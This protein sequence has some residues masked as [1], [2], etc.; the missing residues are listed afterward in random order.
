MT[1]LKELLFGHNSFPLDM[2]GPP[3]FA[4]RKCSFQL[5]TLVSANQDDNSDDFMMKVLD[6]NMSLTLK[7]LYWGTY[8]YD[9][10]VALFGTIAMPQLTSF[11]GSLRLVKHV[12]PGRNVTSL[13]IVEDNLDI[14]EDMSQFRAVEA[15][16]RCI[17]SLCLV[18]YWHPFESPR[19]LLQLMPAL[20]TV[21]ISD[22]FL[23]VYVSH[24]S[25][26]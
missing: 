22:I 8:R 26:S 4:A 7:S 9:E 24:P 19:K 13:S 20:Q 1:N 5:E 17:K 21:Q 15:E 14:Y 11:S 18:E 3:A 6:S 10:I 23:D 12:L 2:K 16:L 25:N